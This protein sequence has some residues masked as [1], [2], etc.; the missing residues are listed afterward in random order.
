[1]L[2][3]YVAPA[4]EIPPSPSPELQ[5][6]SLSLEREEA[7]VCVFIRPIGGEKRRLELEAT[8]TAW[9]AMY[10]TDTFYYSASCVE[11]FGKLC[12]WLVA[13]SSLSPLSRSSAHF[14]IFCWF[15]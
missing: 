1:M 7:Y 14:R 15:L 10:L 2:I 12:G 4:T 3:E 13:V 6:L 9:K 5:N 11:F 8:E